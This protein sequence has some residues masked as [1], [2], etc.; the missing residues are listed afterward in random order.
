MNA[1]FAQF[2][3]EERLRAVRERCRLLADMFSLQAEA[4]W[5][6]C[7]VPL[8]VDTFNALTDLCRESADD[9][10]RLAQEIPG[11]IANWQAPN[12]AAIADVQEPT[13]AAEE[14]N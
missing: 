14:S 2:S 6:A 4:A 13:P 5:L 3:L 9:L 1:E 8:S 7:Q 11:A 10:E 12:Y